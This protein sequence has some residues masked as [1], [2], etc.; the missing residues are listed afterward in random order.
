MDGPKLPSASVVQP[1]RT[2]QVALQTQQ[3]PGLNFRNTSNEVNR[4]SRDVSLYT[5]GKSGQKYRPNELASYW[6][7][8][9]S[10]AEIHL[11]E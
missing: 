10:S 5:K 11:A 7:V 1:A 2:R 6:Q 3:P 9:L 8:H 4:S